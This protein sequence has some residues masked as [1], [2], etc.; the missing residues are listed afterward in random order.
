M[1]FRS[2]WVSPEEFQF[3]TQSSAYWGC[4]KTIE[5]VQNKKKRVDSLFFSI[6]KYNIIS[7]DYLDLKEF[8]TNQIMCVKALRHNQQKI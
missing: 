4:K 2:H 1:W 5:I 8:M 6:Q 7:Q 3:R